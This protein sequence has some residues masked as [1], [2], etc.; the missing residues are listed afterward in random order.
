MFVCA[1]CY[2]P[3]YAVLLFTRTFQKQRNYYINF[4]SEPLI[5]LIILRNTL[6]IKTQ[7]KWICLEVNYLFKKKWK[8]FFKVNNLFKNKLNRFFF[9]K[10]TRKCNFPLFQNNLIVFLFFL[11]TIN[12][13]F[14]SK[15]ISQQYFL[16]EMAYHR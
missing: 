4:A 7:M 15:W 13:L 3:G 16:K 10:D 6:L 1:T 14:L 8:D 2:T 11:S 5:I 12:K 9:Q